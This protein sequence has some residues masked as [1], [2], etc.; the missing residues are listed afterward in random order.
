M[1]VKVLVPVFACHW[2]V[3]VGVPVTVEPVIKP[4]VSNK[5]IMVVGETEMVFA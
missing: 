4:G 3:I 5:H 2:N 1:L